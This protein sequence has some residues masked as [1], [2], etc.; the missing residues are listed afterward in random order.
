MMNFPWIRV[1]AYRQDPFGYE[2]SSKTSPANKSEGELGV[3]NLQVEQV[4]AMR[5]F[6]DVIKGFQDVG[7]D[8]VTTPGSRSNLQFDGRQTSLDAASLAPIPKAV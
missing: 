2:P 7:G 4:A 3:S 8:D 1:C 5:T 6:D